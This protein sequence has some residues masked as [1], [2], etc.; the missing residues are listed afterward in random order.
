MI[1]KLFLHGNIIGNVRILSQQG[2]EI[3]IELQTP[4]SDDEIYQIQI[5][6]DQY[7][8]EF[9]QIDVNFQENQPVRCQA[10]GFIF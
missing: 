3:I 10:R 9:T 5:G 7:N 1:G 8:L 2:N 4:V 6:E